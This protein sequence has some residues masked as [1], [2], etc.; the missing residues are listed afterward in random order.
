VLSAPQQRTGGYASLV[1]LRLRHSGTAPPNCNTADGP[2]SSERPFGQTYTVTE[3]RVVPFASIQR[4]PCLLAIGHFARHRLR[5]PDLRSRTVLGP[6]LSA[7]WYAARLLASRLLTRKMH[8]RR[9]DGFVT[10]VLE[11]IFRGGCRIRRR[12]VAQLASKPRNIKSRRSSGLN[13][14]PPKRLHVGFS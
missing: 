14:M 4:G 8:W 2:R 7:T 6:A 12:R 10:R 3:M 13:V 5:W 9:S 1:R 11:G